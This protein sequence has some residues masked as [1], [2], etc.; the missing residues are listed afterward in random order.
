MSA[1][2][3]HNGMGMG[4]HVLNKLMRDP[5]IMDLFHRAR[6]ICCEYDIPY[7]AGYSVDGQTIYIDRHLPDE[8]S[9]EYHGRKHS[10][11]P[12]RFL[13]DHE[14]FEKAIMDALGWQYSPAHEAATGFERRH[15]LAAGLP[16]DG[17]EKALKPF[18]KADEHE[19]IQS[20]PSDLDMRPYTEPPVDEA[21][22]A[23]MHKAMGGKHESKVSK[24]S[25]DYSDGH[26]SSHCG[27]TS[28]WPRGFCSHFNAPNSCEKV[29]GY[30]QPTK[31]CHLW[32]SVKVDA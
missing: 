5:Q 21:L 27:P 23:R 10:F 13:Q 25:V 12:D 6:R 11:R 29:L 8:I 30:I 22:V 26:A 28:K 9:F 17:Y 24:K 18:I 20:V 31:W 15:V 32:E 4:S 16:W 3:R 1:G 2:H 14:S 7:L 19:K